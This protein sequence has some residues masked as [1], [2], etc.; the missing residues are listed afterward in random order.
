MDSLVEII[1]T[2]V[3]LAVGSLLGKGVKSATKTVTGKTS[4]P[5]QNGL[6]QQQPYS[7]FKRLIEELS[8]LGEPSTVSDEPEYEYDYEPET[9]SEYA[10]ESVAEPQSSYFSYENEPLEMEQTPVMEAFSEH[11]PVQNEQETEP[12]VANRV[13]FDLRQAIIYQ[14]ILQNKYIAEMK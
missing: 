13:S 9:T 1:I 4:S 5:Q 6:P 3:I 11:R 10:Y 12:D 14:T 8:E 2:I 7:D